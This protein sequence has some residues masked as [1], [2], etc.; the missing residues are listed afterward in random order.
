MIP[1][2]TL[3]EY[4]FFTVAK[5]PP[6]TWSAVAFKQWCSTLRWSDGFSCRWPQLLPWIWHCVLPW[7]CISPF[8]SCHALNHQS[9][10]LI[11]ITLA[12]ASARWKPRSKQGKIKMPQ[13][14]RPLLAHAFIKK[15][16]FS[17]TY[18]HNI[19]KWILLTLW[20][21]YLVDSVE[22]S[23]FAARFE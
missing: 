18:W 8:S 5:G 10:E 21:F 9:Y 1:M 3:T 4:R 17:R 14:V 12:K 19:R 13:P 16:V 7:R 23:N 6:G 2:F 20:L 22:L 15:C 11:Y